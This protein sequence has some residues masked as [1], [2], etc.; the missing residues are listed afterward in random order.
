MVQAALGAKLKVDGILPDEE[1]EVTVP[2][3]TQNGRIIKVR[4]AGMPRL[5]S[6]RRGDLLVHVNVE[7]PK[8]LSKRERELLEQFAAERGEEV[9]EARSP[10]QKIRDAFA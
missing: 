1:V 8:K 5:R 4:G 6:D 2:E 10:L 7:I 9:A 3:G